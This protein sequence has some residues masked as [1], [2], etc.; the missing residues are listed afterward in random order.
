MFTSSVPSVHDLLFIMKI[1]TDGR[2]QQSLARST[3]EQNLRWL[4]QL[5]HHR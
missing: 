5:S 2:T 4:S 3:Q 1:F